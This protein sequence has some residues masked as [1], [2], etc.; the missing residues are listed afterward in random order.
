MRKRQIRKY[1]DTLLIELS[2]F[3]DLCMEESLYETF[4]DADDVTIE[5]EWDADEPEVGYV[6]GF[7][8]EAFVN[9]VEITNM[10]SIKDIGFV[11]ATLKE[12]TEAYS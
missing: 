10:M 9:G 11:E 8:W 6:G 12:Y 1:M 2:D 7:S 4:P 3:P 5:F